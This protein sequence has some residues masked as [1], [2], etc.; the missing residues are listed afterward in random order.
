MREQT[1]K[2]RLE[3]VLPTVE[4]Q[5]ATVSNLLNRYECLDYTSWRH[6]GDVCHVGILL[7]DII[8]FLES[9]DTP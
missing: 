9:D 7:A 1:A 2:Q 5:A 6:V 3:E 8:E 4:E